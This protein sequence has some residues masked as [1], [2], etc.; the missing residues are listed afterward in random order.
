MKELYLYYD[1]FPKNKIEE[2]HSF[3]DKQIAYF[4]TFIENMNEGISY[5]KNLFTEFR[6]QFEDVKDDIIAEL[7]NMEYELAILIKPCKRY[8]K[9]G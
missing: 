4:N 6:H 7:E 5:Y 1:F 9:V 8:I 2:I 3:S